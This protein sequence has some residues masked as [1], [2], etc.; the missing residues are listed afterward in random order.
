[1]ISDQEKRGVLGIAFLAAYA[2]GG[3]SDQERA[4]VKSVAEGLG[5]IGSISLSSILTEVML[6]RLD[7][8]GAVA[9]LQS[10]ET[11]LLAYE[12]AVQVCDADG[13]RSEQE[14]KFLEELGQLLGLSQADQEAA[15]EAPDALAAAPLSAGT[16]PT[17]DLP[18]APPPPPAAQAADNPEIQET[19]RNHAILC[20]ALELLPQSLAG[21][22]VIPMQMKMVYR[23]G[24]LHG[25]TLGQD[26]IKDFLATLGIGLTS[27]F[28]E[29]FVRK[30]FGGLLK[31]SVG[32]WGGKL[33]KTGASVAMSFVTTYALGHV[34]NRYYASGRKMDKDTLR[35]TYQSALQQA[36]GLKT[37]YLP[38][39]EQQ[40][41]G[42]DL[43][44]IMGMIRGK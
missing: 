2:D 43:T 38:A 35:S 32:K 29:G 16:L 39:M 1:M 14:T 11:R 21:M 12:V 33:G 19:I 37:Q 15:K 27:Q 23:I 10:E 8:A 18:S 13:L 40:A 31:R 5:E 44:K 25:E 7:M 24:Q 41:S 17:S 34:A 36:E 20:G 30:L 3:N 42:L 26:H 9:L 4:S 22:A 28:L 6:R